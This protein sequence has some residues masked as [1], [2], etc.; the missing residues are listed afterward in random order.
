MNCNLPSGHIFNIDEFNAELLLIAKWYYHHGYVRGK[1]D[2]KYVYL[3]RFIMNASN[4]IKID[5]KD[6]NGL[7]NKIE[8]LR[9]CSQSENCCN[10]SKMVHK[11]FKGVY[12]DK[13]RGFFYSQIYKNRKSYFGGNYKNIIDA[14]ISYNNLALK[15]HGQFAKLNEIPPKGTLLSHI[16]KNK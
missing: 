8:N 7:N 9:L 6:G 5:H 16:Y 12:F 3:H 10:K 1:V 15:H 4:K 14:A 11:N 13:R 2:G